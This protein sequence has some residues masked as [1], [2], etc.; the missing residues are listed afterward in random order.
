MKKILVIVTFVALSS[1]VSKSDYQRARNNAD[2][3]ESL[4]EQKCE[5]YE[6]LRIKYNNLVDEYNDVHSEYQTLQ[7]NYNIVYNENEENEDIIENAKN[8]VRT[9][10]SHFSSFQNGWY[11][12]AYDI[13]RDIRKVENNLDGWW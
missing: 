3:W 8:S 10:K 11:Y 13:E 4:Y 12:N 9:L 7:S 2:Y 5:E 6:T 1:C